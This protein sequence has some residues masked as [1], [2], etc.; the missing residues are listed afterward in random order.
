MV[1][2]L[3]RSAQEGNV[4]AIKELG[5]IYDR[6]ERGRLLDAY[7]EEREAEGERPGKKEARLRESATAGEGTDWGDD[8]KAGLERPN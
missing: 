8:L 1:M 3:W 4:A 2:M 5:R 7:R 6:L